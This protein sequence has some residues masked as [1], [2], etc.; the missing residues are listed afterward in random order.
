MQLKPGFGIDQLKFGLREN[1]IINLIGQPDKTF[2]DEDDDNNLIYRYNQLKISLTFYK[3][4]DG[5]LGYIRCANPEISYNNSKLIGEPIALVTETILG[6]FHNWEIDHYDFFD[7]YL[8]IE[9]WIVLNVEY[10]VVCDVEIGVPYNED[11][12]CKWPD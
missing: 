1:D 8:H 3:H 11:D 2:T 7:T 4:E 5:R 10:E 12:T 6:T 9:N